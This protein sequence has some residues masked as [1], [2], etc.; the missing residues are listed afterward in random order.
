MINGV[1]D[2][3]LE[4]QGRDGLLFQSIFDMP[5]QCQPVFQTQ[6]F[7]GQVAFAQVQFGAQRNQ[8]VTGAQAEA[9]QF[10]D[11]IPP[12]TSSKVNLKTSVEASSYP[13]PIWLWERPRWSGPHPGLNLSLDPTERPGTQLPR[14]GK[15]PGSNPP[16]QRAS[17]FLEAS[18]HLPFGEKNNGSHMR[19]ILR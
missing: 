7:N 5:F 4:G 10:T 18:Q 6:L 16:F 11:W 8:A 3:W 1:F 13:K 15:V 12:L 14:R 9:S 19:R 2:Q 17:R